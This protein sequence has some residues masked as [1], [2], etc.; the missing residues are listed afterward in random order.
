MKSAA[1]FEIGEHANLM[2][3]GHGFGIFLH[4]ATGDN[5]ISLDIH[6]GMRVLLG[7][8]ALGKAILAYMPSEEATRI[9]RSGGYRR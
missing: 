7:T 5:A 8:T 3:E 4:T 2:S 6:L 1:T 9:V